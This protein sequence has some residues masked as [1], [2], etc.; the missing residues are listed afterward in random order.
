MTDAEQE[1]LLQS[2]QQQQQPKINSATFTKKESSCPSPAGGILPVGYPLY[3]CSNGGLRG[4][5]S[6]FST[7]SSTN[8]NHEEQQQE[9]QHPGQ[10]RPPLF[11]PLELPD[12]TS[13][14][15]LLSPTS[16]VRQS[17]ASALPPLAEGEDLALSPK[18]ELKIVEEEKE[19]A[20]E[21]AEETPEVKIEPETT[22]QEEPPKEE[23]KNEEQ[24][25]NNGEVEEEEE[26]M[27]VNPDLEKPSPPRAG[28]PRV[29]SNPFD[30]SDE[31]SAPI[32]PEDDLSP[33]HVF[34]TSVEDI[35]GEGEREAEAQKGTG[36]RQNGKEG[37]FVRKKAGQQQSPASSPEREDGG[38]VGEEE[39][40]PAAQDE[41]D[42]DGRSPLE[43]GMDYEQLMA[44]FESLKES[45]A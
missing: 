40:N 11:S 16:P 17:P 23:E 28:A 13:S 3:P 9:Q 33:V 18:E 24:Q 20:E 7:A 41:E 37:T 19:Q 39:W 6:S 38:K 30:L 2:P 43:S 44:Y 8:D 36:R 5:F 12:P 35:F 26:E 4:S 34:E 42:E 45:T 32:S 27:P 15:V 10:S 21:K 14:Q 22:K 25:R 31:D 29:F 1:P